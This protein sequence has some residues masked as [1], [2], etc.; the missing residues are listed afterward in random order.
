M[1]LIPGALAFWISACRSTQ[2]ALLDHPRHAAG[3]AMQDVKF[4]SAALN[5][6]MP[7]RVYLPE[8]LIPGQK[9]PVVYVLHGGGNN[10]TSWSNYSDV[11]GFAAPAAGSPGMIL[12]MPEGE[13]SYYVNAALKPEDK[14]E[15]YIVHDLIADV[16]ARFPA[17]ADRQHR[18]IMGLSMGGFGAVRLALIH[19][20][21]FVFAG[22]LS[23]AID[24]PERR[25]SIVYAGQWWRFRTTFGPRGSKQWQASDPFLL[26]QTANPAATPY[27]YLTAGEREPLLAPNRRF[28]ARLGE[29]HFA[30]EFHTKPGG[31]DWGEWNSQLPGLFESMNKHLAPAN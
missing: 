25:F 27:I 7:Y 19:P 6:E 23:P 22:A 29:R 8:N 20:D 15:D 28:A 11:G 13:S 18:A 2:L 17:A 21:L 5:R 24:A 14:F 16:E 10:F 4:H 3:V 26:V 30:F 1:L 31:H 12:V 9:L